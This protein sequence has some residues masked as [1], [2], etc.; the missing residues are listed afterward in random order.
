MAAPKVKL[1][2]KLRIPIP[3]KRSQEYAQWDDGSITRICYAPHNPHYYMDPAGEMHPIDLLHEKD[4]LTSDGQ[5]IKLKDKNVVSVG[6]KTGTDKKKYLGLRPDCVQ[7]GSEQL[8]FDLEGVEFDGTDLNL[9]PL[10][11]KVISTRQRCRQ[12]I[13]VSNPISSFKAVFKVTATGLKMLRMLELD[14]FWFYSAATNEFRF[15]IRK[16]VL[17][18]A[19]G[20]LLKDAD[21]NLLNQEKLLSHSLAD[22]GDGTFTYTKTSSPAFAAAI[23]PTEYW[24]DA[25]IVYAESSDAWMEKWGNTW[26]ECY[27]QGSG[28]FS[29]A[30]TEETEVNRGMCGR[31]FTVYY[32]D[33]SLFAFDRS[34]IGGTITAVSV[35][36]TGFSLQSGEVCIQKS[37]H[38]DLPATEADMYAFSGNYY[39][40]VTWT[41]GGANQFDLDAQGL[42]DFIAADPLFKICARSYSIDYLNS[43]PGGN[44]RN[45]CYYSESAND[46]Y[47]SVT[48]TPVVPTVTTSACSGTT[49]NQTTGNGNITATGGANATRRGFCYM[50]GDSGDPDTGDSTVYDDGDFGTGAFQKDITGL[51]A[52]TSYR[53]RAYAVNS[54]GT[55]YGSSVT[56]L[57]KPAAPTNVS[58]TDGVH[59]DKVVITWTKSTG[60][61]GYK[62]YE[63]ANL[64]DTLGD[65]ATYNDF[66]AP[67]PAITPGSAVASD[68]AFPA[69]VALS[70]SGESTSNGASRTYKVVAFNGTGDSSDSNTDTGYR[71][72]GALTYQWQRSAADSD[73]NYSNIEGAITEAY[74]DTGAPEN[75]DGRYYKCILDATGAAQQI[76]AVDRGYRGSVLQ[77]ALFFGMNF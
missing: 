65:V 66:A 42:A 64:L 21:G 55:A 47:A 37:A 28:T 31:L 26:A 22:N 52:G 35:V 45:G 44:Y 74:N 60:A 76:T 54:A 39:Y 68:G 49:N 75:G 43:T 9:N 13:P 2:I 69:H 77:A 10:E 34:G 36:I 14:E 62:V 70:I 23:L 50:V 41:S 72:V 67:A 6:R 56:V 17:V 38:A 8:E 18:D 15:R 58:A 3:G 20:F 40:K 7:D 29:W 30:A 63:G 1:N 61:T 59:T 46:P 19:D 4:S 48:W 24:I 71:G 33:R 57:T 16:P 53:V 25:D 32:L 51:S 5:A 73:A 12:L 27:A 11:I